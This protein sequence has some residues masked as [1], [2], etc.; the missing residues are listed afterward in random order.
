MHQNCKSIGSQGAHY[1][2]Q[3]PSLINSLS[4]F[5]SHLTDSKMNFGEK[6]LV[7]EEGDK[8]ILSSFV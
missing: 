6:F 5:W 3:N 8:E 2:V 1:F 4:N 7:L